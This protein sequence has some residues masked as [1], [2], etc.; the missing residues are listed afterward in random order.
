MTLTS[1]DGRLV[2]L[3]QVGRVVVREEDRILKLRD[4]T[5]TITEQSDHDDAVQPPQVTA[6]VLK[7]IQP[8]IDKLP[9]GYR[10]EVAGNAE[11]SSK[12]NTALRC[13]L[14]SSCP[15]SIPSGS[16]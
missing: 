12:A 5:P 14:L 15:R 11:E 7:A 2:P 4:R 10:V 16:T 9:D 6:E 8:I 13:S 3:S 1:S